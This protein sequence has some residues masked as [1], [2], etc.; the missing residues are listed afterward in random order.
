MPI[1]RSL[2]PM[3]I[4]IHS[5]HAKKKT[6]PQGT[7][8][9][10]ISRLRWM[11][12]TIAM[13]LSPKEAPRCFKKLKKSKWLKKPDM[14]TTSFHE[15]FP[16]KKS[17]KKVHFRNFRIQIKSYSTCCSNRC[18]QFEDRLMEAVTT[19]APIGTNSRVNQ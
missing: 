13:T 5:R 19:P 12:T 2:L 11:Q 15:Y 10:S 14:K 8:K 4:L 16:K 18:N 3:I 17:I 1:L 7:I 9:N 6:Q